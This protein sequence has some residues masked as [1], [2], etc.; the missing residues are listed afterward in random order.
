MCV[1]D[2]NPALVLD[3]KKLAAFSALGGGFLLFPIGDRRCNRTR[4]S[5]G[6]AGGNARPSLTNATLGASRLLHRGNLR[7]RTK[8]FSGFPSPVEVVIGTLTSG[9]IIASV[10][11]PLIKCDNCEVPQEALAGELINLCR[12]LGQIES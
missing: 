6:N 10:A 7:P 5:V 9:A 2:P 1:Y 3:R 11:E 4:A 8:P 12:Q